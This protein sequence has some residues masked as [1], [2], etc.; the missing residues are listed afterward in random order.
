MSETVTP[1]VEATLVPITYKR[2]QK[3]VYPEVAAYLTQRQEIDWTYED[4]VN[5]AHT[6]Y[7]RSET[8]YTRQV[9]RE[10]GRYFDRY[11]HS[12]DRAA[13]M[14]WRRVR[15]AKTLEADRV[16]RD[17][18]EGLKTGLTSSSNLIVKWIAE[19]AIFASQGQEVEEYGRDI[20]AILPATTEQIWA[21]AK[22]K[23][24]MCDVFD[25]MYNDAE[26][27]GIFTDGAPLPG[28][29]ELM[30]LRNYIRRNYGDS[31]TRDIMRNVDRAVKAIREDY[32]KRLTEAKA[33]WEGLDE[34][35]RSERSR[36]AA[37]TRAANREAG[38]ERLIVPQP[39]PEVTLSSAEQDRARPIPQISTQSAMT[40]EVIRSEI[41]A[42]E[43]PSE[44]VSE[45]STVR[46]EVHA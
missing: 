6:E 2:E 8:E 44:K 12:E 23:R 24:G 5:A 25:R 43:T 10:H 17:A 29:R 21:E 4:A 26:A 37:A 28:F 18:L 32:D 14:E 42:D 16:K 7:S 36:R 45:G 41:R 13:Q 39:V 9:Q 19:N 22:D 20:L 34:A 30:A 35:W 40:G 46:F 31:Y 11:E 38:T 3:R 27:A 1:E 15:D 33:E